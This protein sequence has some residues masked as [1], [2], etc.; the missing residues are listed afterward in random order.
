MAHAIKDNIARFQ[1]TSGQYYGIDIVKSD[2]VAE[3]LKDLPATI[4]QLDSATMTTCSFNDVNFDLIFQDGA[5]DT[6]HVVHEIECLYPLLCGNGKGY[7]VMHDCYGPAEEG[8]QR[9][10][11]DPR[12]HF[13][14]VRL[15]DMVYGLAILR[16]MDGYKEHKHWQGG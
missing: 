3:M 1:Y 12:Y 16:K 8:Y 13:E 2:E 10:I 5:H 7:L 9:I 6:E 4:Y 14:H 11:N 15:D